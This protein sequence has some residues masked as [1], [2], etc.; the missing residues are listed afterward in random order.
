MAVGI[1]NLLVP[2]T[3]TME[4]Q[5]WWANTAAWWSCVSG[6]QSIDTANCQE[7]S[8]SPPPPPLS[9]TRPPR[10]RPSPSPSQELQELKEKGNIT[11]SGALVCASALHVVCLLWVASAQCRR[12]ELA[13]SSTFLQ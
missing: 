8:N 4:K 2:W 10:F 11:N 3:T 6:E 9:P 1:L 7:S 5:K 13:P 12:R